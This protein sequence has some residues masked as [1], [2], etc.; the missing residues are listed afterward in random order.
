MN[1][2]NYS[3]MLEPSVNISP[4]R[5]Q[6]MQDSM[7]IDHETTITDVELAHGYVPFQKL[8]PTFA[9]LNSLKSGTIFPGLYDPRWES[10]HAIGGE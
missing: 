4:V 1:D 10:K 8:C 5:S 7:C 6:D 3:E 9:P 2:D